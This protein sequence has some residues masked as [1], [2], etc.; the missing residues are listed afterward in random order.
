MAKLIA[1]P[2]ALLRKH[3]VT[4]RWHRLGRSLSAVSATVCATASATLL[5]LLSSA[6]QPPEPSS[7][8][9]PA[10]TPRAEFIAIAER[11]EASDASF[12]GNAQFERLQQ[13][14]EQQD[15]ATHRPI[16]GQQLQ[17]I[18]QLA[19][20]HLRLGDTER[21]LQLLLSVTDEVESQGSAIALRARWLRLL[22]MTHLRRA[23]DVNCRLHRRPGACIFPLRDGGVH[24][25]TEPAAAARQ[26]YLEYLRLRPGDG[27]AAWLIN[28]LS[29][30][31]DDYPQ[32]VPEYFR[33]PPATF[34]SADDIGRFEDIAPQLGIDTFNH[35]G[36]VVT[37]DFDGD[38]LLDI[39]TST[40]HPRGPL[41]YY[42]NVGDGSFAE[43][44]VDAGLDGQLGGLNLIGG[45]YDGDG[46]VDLLVLRGA[47]L[48]Q[49]GQ[50]RNSL[51]R[52]D[53]AG[54][55]TDVTRQAG[56]AEPA[57]PTQAATWG[58]FD[59]DG[60]LD[61][62]IVNERADAQSEVSYPAQLFHNRGDGTFVDIAADAGVSNGAHGKGVTA[63][64]FDNDGDL[65]IY[66]S[67]I[68]PNRLYR[69]DG[70]LTFVD[71]ASQLGVQEPIGRSFAAWFF[72]YDNDGW[73]DLFVGA[74][75]ATVDDVAADLMGAPHGGVYP[76]LYRNLGGTFDDVTAASGL[77]HVYLPMGANFGDLDNDGWLDI[78]LS[79]GD[80]SYETLVPNI[81]LRNQGGRR[82]VDITTSSGLGHL[83]K[84]HGVAFADLDNDGD[85]DL[86]H[87]LGGFVPGDPYHNALFHNPGHGHRHLTVQLEGKDSPRRGIG[88]RL[89]VVV[90][91]PSGQRSI[92]RA[93]GSVSSFG[94]SPRRQEIGLGDA[95]GVRRLEVW[96]P[97]SGSRQQF[98]EV[99]MDS[100]V[101]VREGVAGI[102]LLETP[103]YDL[104]TA[105][106]AA[107]PHHHTASGGA[108]H[109]TP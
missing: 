72:D 98:T 49:H 106:E 58:D 26:A 102:E 44:T 99:P 11:L 70:N 5:L 3:P 8:Q 38:G 37:E 53:G 76:R 17:V 86:Y 33:I 43:R 21:A 78:Y 56:L 12:F 55:F 60:H 14:F 18:L 50:I 6:C 20:Q 66:V 95:L 48:F 84:G 85:Q 4:S 103:S 87:Q 64:D 46:D 105:L 15:L 62:Y 29:M 69:N 74:Y 94:G 67:N 93:V 36:G 59:N 92:H 19:S 83:Q 71:V 1:L 96:W 65:D 77:Q 54:R 23:E 104:A 35:C 61:L 40:W 10:D 39:V 101:R 100:T 90:E 73:L 22:A 52:N 31:L 30:A 47:W 13:I 109:G 89:Q 32:G 81:M 88:A 45:D 42:R 9:E 82:F 57:R 25:E 2:G 68:G 41:T 75:Q 7:D 16:N 97:A 91:T 79:T 34:E 108:H 107:S 51:L 27:T 80:P 63:G 24:G 28:V